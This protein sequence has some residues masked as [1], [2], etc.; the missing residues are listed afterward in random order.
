MKINILYRDEHYLVVQKLAPLLVHRTAGDKDRVN[1]MKLIKEQEGL[2]LYPIHRLDKQVSGCIIFGLY[3]EAVKEI[4][5][6]WHSD[7]V[8]KQYL[9][10]VKGTIENEGIFDFKLNNENKI[11]QNAITLYHPLQKFKE[12]T[13]VEIEIKTGR[14]HQIRR[15]FS[16]RM[17]HVIGDRKY[18]KKI[19]NDFYKN[20]YGLSRIFLHS[21]RLSFHHPFLNKQIVVECELDQE[22]KQII[23]QLD[24]FC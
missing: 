4:Q 19:I 6:I 16:R 22:L 23:E 20:N 10:L 21:H 12:S 17:Q 14:Y 11:P 7:K 9:A 3:P 8:K 18:G 5:S 24:L 2:Y 1:L 13:L 15:H